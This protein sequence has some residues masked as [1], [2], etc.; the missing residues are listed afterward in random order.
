MEW[1]IGF[2]IAGI[3][4]FVFTSPSAAAPTAG[5]SH[6]SCSDDASTAIGATASSA[7]LFD[8]HSDAFNHLHSSSSF[9]GSSFDDD[10]LCSHGSINPANGL[11]MIGCIDIEGN[12]YG[13]DS[14]SLGDDWM[15]TGS[16]TWSRDD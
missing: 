3:A 10:T 14:T 4:L 9:S 8:N 16:D 5:S 12:P 15:D 13:V 2:L 1:L 11:P 7:S 6:D